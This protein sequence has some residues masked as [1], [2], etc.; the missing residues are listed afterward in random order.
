MRAIFLKVAS[1]NSALNSKKKNCFVSK[2]EKK[3]QV[4]NFFR[5]L[6]YPVCHCVDV[7]KKVLQ[8]TPL[9]AMFKQREKF[10]HVLR[11]VRDGRNRD[12]FMLTVPLQFKK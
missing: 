8:G 5:T 1:N 3:K 12:F 2:K 6:S 10:P 9:F 4:S 7:I 11:R